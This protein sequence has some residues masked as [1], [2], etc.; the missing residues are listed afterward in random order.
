MNYLNA[1]ESS[2]I[3]NKY[4]KNPESRYAILIDGEW[5]CGKTYYVKEILTKEINEKIENDD[6]NYKKVIY[7]TLN[8]ITSLNEI[9]KLFWAQIIPKPESLDNESASAALEISKSILIG[10]TNFFNIKPGKVNYEKFI[11]L[12]ECIIIFD[13]LE[14]CNMD[15]TTVMGYIN[16]FLEQHNSKVIMIASQKEISKKNIYKN[17]ELKYL[18]AY[19]TIKADKK[20]E[21]SNSSPSDKRTTTVFKPD[22]I[23][24]RTK[25]IFEKDILFS[26]IKEKVIG[27]IINF[28]TDINTVLSSGLFN[29]KDNAFDKEIF[30]EIVNNTF[31]KYGHTNIRT[32]IFIHEILVEILEN[33]DNDIEY[34]DTDE[35]KEVL[36]II[37][38]NIVVLSVLF[39]DGKDISEWTENFDYSYNYNPDEKETKTIWGIKKTTE[40]SSPVFFRFVY[41]LVQYSV[42]DKESIKK[43]INLYLNEIRMDKKDKN[44]PLILLRNEWQISEDIENEKLI[45]KIID[46]IKNGK[47]SDISIRRYPSVLVLFVRLEMIGFD[48]DID[49]VVSFMIKNIEKSNEKDLTLNENLMISSVKENEIYIAYLDKIRT[50][51]NAKN[52]SRFKKSLENCLKQDDWL[53]SLFE[54]SR[55][56]EIFISNSKQFLSL[57]PLET[58]FS[59]LEQSTPKEIYRF[60]LLLDS[61]YDFNVVNPAF[62]KDISQLRELNDKIETFLKNTDGNYVKKYNLKLILL[63]LSELIERLKNNNKEE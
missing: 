32:L 8:G 46:Y 40:N 26:K 3:I 19:N 37:I 54:F 51:T 4:L 29:Y 28:R 16:S 52:S 34:E 41:K 30:I 6:I 48:I 60:Y 10:I 59:L 24:K 44:N 27:K 18:L 5:G 12:K 36:I 23:I 22:K 7:I 38:N 13:D 9:S 58:L 62:F 11:S 14:R 25:E 21:K 53:E 39:K 35:K 61:V 63:A 57:L 50:V 33:I 55:T 20:D 15:I 42:L 56:H 45:K 31:N 2:E 1:S 49:S 47:N 43:G 17:L